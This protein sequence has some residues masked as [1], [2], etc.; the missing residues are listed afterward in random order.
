MTS[1]NLRHASMR[2]EGALKLAE[3]VEVSGKLRRLDVTTNSITSRGLCALARS[4]AQHPAIV[5]MELWGNRFDSAACLAWI[6]PLQYIKL[7]IAVQEVDN[8]YHC[9]RCE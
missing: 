8:A 2:D 5:Q 1:R 7:D 4:V 3:V 6:A 9:V